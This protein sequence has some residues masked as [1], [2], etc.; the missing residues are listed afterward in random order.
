M[1]TQIIT[2]GEDLRAIQPAWDALHH[3]ARGNIFQTSEWLIRWWEFYGDQGLLRVLVVSDEE[4]LVGL[5]PCFI[6]KM[7]CGPLGCSRLRFLG[8][9]VTYGEYSPLILPSHEEKVVPL[10]VQFCAELL[11]RGECDLIDFHHFSPTSRFMILLLEGLGASLRVTFTAESLPRVMTELPDDW[12]TYRKGLSYHE[13]GVTGRYERALLKNGAE[14]EIIDTPAG[15]DA[16]D[17]YV[18][19]HTLGW[20]NRG[21]KGFFLTRPKFEAF[22]RA[23]TVDLLK[24][25]MTRLFFFKKD[26]RRFAVLQ[27]FCVHDH[28]CLYLNGRDTDHELKRYSP[29]RILMLLAF[30]EAIREGYRHCD[31]TEG[32]ADYKYRIGGQPCWYAR[33]IACRKG[34]G[35]LKGRLLIAGLGAR[36]LIYPRARQTT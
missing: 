5:V 31:L 27:A 34:L 4:Q 16:F 35:G 25:N 2:V 9:N 13:R 23:V 30:R 3:A 1:K 22:L 26:N 12:E 19:L 36:A 20:Q 32:T 28:Y 21:E 29:G 11:Q 8:E 14:F 33:G 24:K 6:Q 10:A 15:A 7:G 17:D 18:R